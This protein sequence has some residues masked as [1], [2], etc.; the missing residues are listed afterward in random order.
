MGELFLNVKETNRKSKN[1][2]EKEVSKLK[3]VGIDSVN[4]VKLTNSS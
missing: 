3:M 1:L 2:W 4:L